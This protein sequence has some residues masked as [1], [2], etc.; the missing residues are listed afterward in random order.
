MRRTSLYMCCVCIP[1]HY[2]LK[3][4]KVVLKILYDFIVIEISL[5][6]R[7]DVDVDV[8][9]GRIK[10][11]TLKAL[12]MV[13]IWDHVIFLLSHR[14]RNRFSQY[15]HMKPSILINALLTASK[16]SKTLLIKI[17]VTHIFAPRLFIIIIK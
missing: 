12:G 13:C 1:V 14:G 15:F 5:I 8:D 6:M 9:V 7:H 10:I 4:E 17:Y 3:N 16:Q 2:L 11:C